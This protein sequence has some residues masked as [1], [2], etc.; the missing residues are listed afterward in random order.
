MRDIHKI[1]KFLTHVMNGEQQEAED[2]L[3]EDKQLA[4]EKGLGRDPAGRPFEGITGFQYALWAYDWRMW[5]MIKTYLDPYDAYKQ[6]VEQETLTEQMGFG[7]HYNYQELLDA[8]NPIIEMCRIN[9]FRKNWHSVL[10]YGIGGAQKKIPAHLAQEYHNEIFCKPIVCKE[11]ILKGFNPKKNIFK[12]QT[13]YIEK[14]F[15]ES[16]YDNSWWGLVSYQGKLGETFAYDVLQNADSGKIITVNMNCT[17][18]HPNTIKSHYFYL[19]EL[20]LF[21]ATQLEDLQVILKLE[22]KQKDRRQAEIARLQENKQQS[23][24]NKS[25]LQQS[26]FPLKNAISSLDGMN[27]SNTQRLSTLNEKITEISLKLN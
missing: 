11:S 1:N 20:L 7:K 18:T 13:N 25:L 12:R 22:G 24:D 5:E 26:I 23:D 19:R 16:S 3:K 21:R 27:L 6:C 8:F 10:V 15:G 17:T 4:L 14:R 9:D 2:M